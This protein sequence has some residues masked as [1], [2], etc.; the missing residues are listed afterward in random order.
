VSLLGGYRTAPAARFNIAA[1]GGVSF[2]SVRRE[3]NT[4]SRGS[5]VNGRSTFTT[6]ANAWT[7][8]IDISAPLSRRVGV[9]FP[10]RVT[11]TPKLLP[12]TGVDVRAGFGITVALVKRVV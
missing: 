12:R 3:R 10:V 2:I 5:V 11:T 7:G 9:V 6:S 8:G 4:T 1:L